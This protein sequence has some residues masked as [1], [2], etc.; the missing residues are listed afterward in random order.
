MFTSKPATSIQTPEAENAIVTGITSGLLLGFTDVI[1]AVSM[2]NLIFSGPLE[3]HLSRGIAVALLTSI[4]H[5]LF[6]LV[7]PGSPGIVAT[8]QDHPTVVMAVAVASIV[9]GSAPVPFATVI[10]FIFLSTFLVGCGLFLLGSFGLG[11]LVRYV[12]YPVIGGFLAGTGWLLIRGSIGTMTDYPL[13]FSSLPA[14]FSSD[15]ILMWLPGWILGT[16]IYL[17]IRRSQK[18]FV[19]PA[20]IFGFVALFYSTL[21]VTGTPLS[22][23]T[24]QGLLLGD[25]ATEI[26][27]RVPYEALDA[28]W[29][30]VFSQLGQVGAAIFLLTTTELL[31]TLSALEVVMGRN[32]ETRDELRR[33]GLANIISSFSGG[34]VGYHS[35][36]STTLLYRMGGSKRVSGSVILIVYALFFMGGGVILPY[37][38]RALIGGLLFSLG[39]EFIH[40]WVIQGWRKFSLL[41]Y[42]VIIL[43]VLI[44]AISG[45][46][47]AVVAGTLVMVMVFVFSYSQLDIFRRTASGTELKSQVERNTY[48]QQAL[49]EL[50]QHTFIMELQGYIFF[51]TV[52]TVLR[53]VHERLR[54]KS[55]ETELLFLILDFRLVKG[56]DSSVALGLNRIKNLAISHNFQLIVTHME[57]EFQYN[58]ERNG[59]S[60]ADSVLQFA[61]IDR[62]LEW[63]EDALLE[64]F[65]ITKKHIPSTLVAQ[66]AEFGLEAE[67]VRH[68]MDFLERI[69]LKPN[70][71]LA[72]QGEPADAVYFIELGQVSVFL[73][74]DNERAMRL[75][76]M[77]MGTI[78]GEIGFYLHQKR[79]AS[80]VA[81]M[82]TVVYKLSRDSLNK[83]T[84]QAPE[85]AALVNRLMTQVLA[86]RLVVANQKLAS[87]S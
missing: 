4:I 22:S 7:L 13:T 36:G 14:L 86:E 63:C 20:V 15:Q 67:Q 26:T 28:D 8:V 53:K 6:M 23:A 87:L 77:N 12:P 1:F 85:L 61:D 21:L 47:V 27:W 75:H 9:A 52:N 46:L 33:A 49:A 41:D 31:M 51:G 81:T 65:K 43:I 45:F 3:I 73:E 39:L 56:L 19:V 2:A 42:S 50:G 24:T 40:T 80:M 11:E 17:S 54:Q 32:I 79:S 66:L 84:E 69:E 55:E 59:F 37:I 44:V 83:M 71:V 10:A 57:R 62:G 78:V 74:L 30:S 82:N 34:M 48:H 25:F 38:P 5:I 18:P 35:P 29:W 70:E 64:H 58:L 72:R 16:L 76:L 60:C 68:L